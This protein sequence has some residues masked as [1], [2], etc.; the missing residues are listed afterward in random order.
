MDDERWVQNQKNHNVQT[1]LKAK[2]LP[3]QIPQ[4]PIHRTFILGNRLG[5]HARPASLLVKRL[6]NFQSTVRAEVGG[7]A[8]NAKSILGLLSLAAGYG[9]T[10]KFAVAGSDAPEAMRA[11]EVLFE[12]NFQEAY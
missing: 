12:T 1:L 10:I 11:I 8:A 4:E 9:T 6:G 2:P 7:E 5:L 3:K